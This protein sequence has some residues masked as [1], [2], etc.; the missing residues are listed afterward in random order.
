MHPALLLLLR[1]RARGWLRRLRQSLSSPRHAVFFLLGLLLFL[2]SVA[3][4]IAMVVLPNTGRPRFNPE[5]VSGTVASVLLVLC[6][7]NL[8]VKD[9]D[10]AVV[11]S[12][13]EMDF[14]FAGPFTR[15]QLL[16]YKI[17][18]AV[19]VISGSGLI[20]SG[21][22]CVYTPRW[23]PTFVGCTLALLFAY[24]FQMAVT[25]LHDTLAE[26]AYSP[27]RKAVLFAAL[28]LLAGAAWHA[29]AAGGGADFGERFRLLRESPWGRVLL[30]PF[31]VF[32]KTLTARTLFP[33][34]ALWGGLAVLI[35]LAL[36]G[37]V[38]WLDADYRETSLQRSR[39]LYERVGRMQRSGS[40]FAGRSV[41]RTG[42]RLPLP[43][44]WGGAGPIAWRQMTA[45]LRKAN[46][47]L[48]AMFL[49][50]PFLVVL[51]SRAALAK[52][53]WLPLG[54]MAYASFI[55]FPMMLSFDFRADLDHLE[56]LKMLPFSA[57]GVA[58]GEL[59]GP[60]LVSTLLHWLVVV[61][62]TAAVYGPRLELLA[63]A[64]FAPV[65]NLLFFALE[66]LVFLLFPVRVTTS[67]APGMHNAARQMLF[68]LA[69][70]VTLVIALGLAAGVGGLA[71]LAAGQ[72]WPAA[73]AGAWLA[74]TALAV[75]LVPLVGWAFRRFDVSRETV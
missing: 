39:R 13:G 58:A 16:L 69:R 46:P 3:I 71:Y 63:A 74:V 67:A 48:L 75:S 60:V 22:L 72:S 64:V 27:T 1:L 52:G 10:R 51:F 8:L 9:T 17:V 7:G 24:F 18:A 47:T 14:L 70:M 33:D 23:L 2:A 43:P 31:V 36:L 59:L 62:L 68:T 34:L 32:G 65:V 35:N 11:F 57:T 54:L 6:L 38:L 40:V 20:Y 12:P 30:A 61:C 5:A 37:L 29:L 56:E 42:W 21:W 4:P 49:A 19:T 66:N 53:P 15:K 25:L 45:C 41:R 73:A 55:L 44:R 28:A 26:R 50:I